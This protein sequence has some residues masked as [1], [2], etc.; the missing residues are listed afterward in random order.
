MISETWTLCATVDRMIRV[1]S[2]LSALS[3]L[4]VL[5]VLLVP[6]LLAVGP[7]RFAVRWPERFSLRSLLFRFHRSSPAALARLLWRS[8]TS[9][10]RLAPG[11]RTTGPRT[12]VP[13]MTVLFMTLFAAAL[14]TAAPVNGPTLIGPPLTAAPSDDGPLVMTPAGGARAEGARAGTSLPG[15]GEAGPGVAPGEAGPARVSATPDEAGTGESPAG[16]PGTPDVPDPGTGRVWP[17]G[18]RP[19]VLRGWQPPDFAYGRG[20][21]G[22]DLA[23]TPGAPV[24]AAAPGLVSF[25]G[26]V[27]G[28]GVLSITLSGTG[29]PPLRTTYQPVEPLVGKGDAVTAGQV[30]GTVS[31]G[32]FHCPAACLHWGLLRSRTYLDPLSL[33][34]PEL[35]RR[36]PSRLLPV[37]GIP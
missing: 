28:R 29:E 31:P 15:T 17:V 8:A 19:M 27:A 22:V 2:A 20:H 33:L 36:G 12:T 32:P 24:R 21:R 26:R 7:E 37:F 18:S 9:R 23:T 5:L 10:G 34:P 6:S 13:L 4:L 35:L 14:L 25:A 3:V 1:L 16:V 30:V 11:P